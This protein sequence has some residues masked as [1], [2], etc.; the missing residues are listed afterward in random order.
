MRLVNKIVKEKENAN[1]QRRPRKK[2]GSVII[3]TN[4][5]THA[6]ILRKE[7]L[8]IGWKICPIF[9]TVRLSVIGRIGSFAGWARWVSRFGPAETQLG[10][11]SFNKERFY[12]NIY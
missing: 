12:S 1:N 3:E 9:V 11:L 4:E 5:E 6:L 7:K 10:F 8:N 2:E